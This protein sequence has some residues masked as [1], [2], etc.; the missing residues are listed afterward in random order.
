MFTKWILKIG[1]G[2]PNET[3]KLY[4]DRYNYYNQY[5]GTDSNE[6]FDILFGERVV[7]AM[8][9]N[10]HQA[11]FNLLDSNEIKKDINGDLPLFIFVMMFL[12]TKSFRD[13]VYS[14]EKLFTASVE[15]IYETVQ[16]HCP[17]LIKGNLSSLLF[18]AAH[19]KN[20]TYK[21]IQHHM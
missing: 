12:E 16:K 17:K 7:A 2:S 18:S 13:G 6:I 21:V 5:G 15:L 19:Y 20:Y 11:H 14:Q 1:V 3:A 4:C 8:K 10:N 9:I